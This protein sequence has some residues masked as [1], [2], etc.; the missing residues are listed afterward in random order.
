[1]QVRTCLYTFVH[2]W[3]FC[4]LGAAVRCVRVWLVRRTRSRAHNFRAVAVMDYFLALL[5][6]IKSKYST[7]F[8]SKLQNSFTCV[9]S[10]L[11]KTE[12]LR[13]LFI[14]LVTDSTRVGQIR[15]RRKRMAVNLQPT[16]VGHRCLSGYFK[17]F[18]DQLVKFCSSAL[19]VRI[20]Y[21]Q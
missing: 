4:R 13:S 12:R 2:V 9:C 7:V 20:L 14:F 15:R 19:L 5:S 21:V 6:P 8:G 10:I 17:D 1:M 3:I 11:S 18:G 16:N